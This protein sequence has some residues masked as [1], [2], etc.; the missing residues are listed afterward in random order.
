MMTLLFALLLSGNPD[1]EWCGAAEAPDPLDATLTIAADDE[2]GE[3]MILSGTV[4]QADGAT[5][6]PDVLLY[7]YHT[8][9]RGIYPRRGDETGNGRRHGYLR[10]W[11]RTGDDG[12]YEVRSIRPAQYPS[13]RE[14]A[15]VHVTVTPPGR[16]E[17]WID[18]FMFTDDPVLTERQ[19]S[20]EGIIEL[21]RNEDGTWIGHRDI[22]L[23]P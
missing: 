20:G 8:N 3:R 19:L 7:F 16:E 1:C 15:H 21:T 4:Y 14:A 9:A 12:T 11:L 2:P 18:S 23:K 6:A 22:V 13:R 10:G 5:P 17:D